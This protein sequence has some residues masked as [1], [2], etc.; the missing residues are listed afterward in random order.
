[1]GVILAHS[2]CSLN[3]SLLLYLTE[4]LE[5]FLELIT[6]VQLEN[7]SFE[8]HSLSF[9]LASLSSKP[10]DLE[11]VNEHVPSSPSGKQGQWQYLF[12]RAFVKLETAVHGT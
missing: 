11:H 4:N 7:M 8:V 1:M 5:A 2:G 6:S 3:I 12:H 9:G 10:C